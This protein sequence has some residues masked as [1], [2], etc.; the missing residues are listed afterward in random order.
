M[1]VCQQHQEG[2]TGSCKKPFTPE[3]PTEWS[4]VVINPEVLD[5]VE[6]R[7]YLSRVLHPTGL[8][9][10]QC[11]GLPTALQEASIYAGKRV[12]CHGCSTMYK[13]R[14]GTILD[15]SSL[16]I[17]QFYT[18]VLMIKHGRGNPEIGPVV[19]LH[20]SSVARWRAKLQ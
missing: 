18:L 12:R 6:V 19:G 8:R 17:C 9:C 10:P 7:L 14:S 20:P 3:E 16:S 15:R 4:S 13:Y 5:P 2:L 1:E 11:G